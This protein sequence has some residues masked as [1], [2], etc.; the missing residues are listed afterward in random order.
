MGLQILRVSL[1]NFFY[2]LKPFKSLIK[3]DDKIYEKLNENGIVVI[4]NFFNEEDFKFVK[5]NIYSIE[6]DENDN[7][8]KLASENNNSNVVWVTGKIHKNY[9]KTEKIYS[10]IDYNFKK[11]LPYIEKVLKLK[12]NSDIKYNY[13]NLSISKMKRILMT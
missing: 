12:I 4:D 9:E 6:N 11:Y 10:K 1:K 7:T 5:K 2:K 3:K 8:I 13:Q